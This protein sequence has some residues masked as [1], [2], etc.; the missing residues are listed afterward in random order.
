MSQSG[1]SDFFSPANS[2]EKVS[3]RGAVVS[4]GFEST[5]V[6][7]GRSVDSGSSSTGEGSLEEEGREGEGTGER[8]A[9]VVGE[10]ELDGAF[11]G[12]DGGAAWEEMTGRERGR[13]VAP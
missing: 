1:L 9:C 5:K 2:D 13:T 3:R 11:W 8:G 7:R 4:H 6:A 12:V 10:R